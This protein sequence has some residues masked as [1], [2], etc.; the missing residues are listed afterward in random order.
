MRYVAI[1]LSIIMILA[2]VITVGATE[3]IA[4]NTTPTE[5]SESTVLAESTI[6]ETQEKEL[7]QNSAFIT[8]A[9]DTTE[10]TE[11]TQSTEKKEQE[12]PVITSIGRDKKKVLIKWETIDNTYAYRIYV[13]KT[14]DGQ[15]RRIGDTKTNQFSY[16]APFNQTLY[17][18]VRCI[19]IYGNFTSLYD[20]EGIKFTLLLDTPKIQKIENMI[21]GVKISWNKVSYA[22]KYFIFYR[23]ADTNKFTKI[24]DT[25]STSFLFKT[26]NTGTYFYTVRCVSADKKTFTSDYEKE[27]LKWKFYPAPKLVNNVPSTGS[28]KFTWKNVSGISEYRIYVKDNGSKWKY[29]ETVNDTK[30]YYKDAK[31][32]HKYTFTVKCSKDGKAVSY[33]NNGITKKYIAAPKISSVTSDESDM[34]IRWNKIS[35]AYKYHVFFY[36][37]KKWKNIGSTTATK[38]TYSDGYCDFYKDKTGGV[39]KFTV[40]CADKNN[41]FISSFYSSGYNFKYTFVP[42]KTKVQIK[43]PYLS[44]TVL[45]AG[46]ETYATTMLLKFHKFKINE[47]TFS[48]KYLIQ[49]PVSYSDGTAYGPDMDSAMAGNVYSGWGINAKGMAKCINNYLKAV[50]SK[51]RAYADTT[52]SLQWLSN[53][54]VSKGIP[55]LVWSTSQLAPTYVADSWKVNYVNGSDHKKIGATEKWMAHEHCLV[56]VGYDFPNRRYIYNDSLCKDRSKG[57]SNWAKVRSETRFKQLGLQSIVIK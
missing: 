46:C 32:N 13:K 17:Y 51:K 7:F 56:L 20:K 8:K 55:V 50:G 27:G 47:F 38:F 10:S 57:I 3:N 34:I 40:R 33:H 12:P 19:D 41:K 18:T 9:G 26:K 28:Q 48:S 52:H 36:T 39:Y 21:N 44:Q 43:C 45:S 30:Y 22:D 24:G 4:E 29:I 31:S 11:P 25:K 6:T 37:G 2:P 5:I 15:Y 49:K 16:D 42:E 54:Y 14:K 1:F 23:K 35:G 53:K